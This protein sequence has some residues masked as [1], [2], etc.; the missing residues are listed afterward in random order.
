MVPQTNKRSSKPTVRVRSSDP[1]VQRR[2]RAQVEESSRSMQS[3]FEAVRRASEGGHHF[4]SAS[5]GG[6]QG[7]RSASKS[8]KEPTI[9]QRPSITFRD[10]CKLLHNDDN[11]MPGLI[12]ITLYFAHAR[13]P[14][15][16]RAWAD[17]RGP[18]G[19][20]GAFQRVS[21]DIRGSRTRAVPSNMSTGRWRE[22]SMMRL[23]EFAWC[24][25]VRRG[26]FRARTPRGSIGTGP[27]GLCARA[28]S[29]YTLVVDVRAYRQ[30]ERRWKGVGLWFGWGPIS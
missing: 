21:R 1:T 17:E 24:T 10:T 15:G 23:A 25:V 11:N 13:G 16:S 2:G 8:R 28:S 22:I 9:S 27:D 14:G 4:A 30:G 20:H 19:A 3:R 18:A 29:S 6:R 12:C 26:G 7:A 5:A